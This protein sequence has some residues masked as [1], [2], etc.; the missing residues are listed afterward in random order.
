MTWRKATSEERA[1]ALDFE[2]VERKLPAGL[3]RDGEPVYL[4]VDFLDGTKG[5]H[6]PIRGLSGGA[7]TTSYA[8]FLLYSLFYSGVLGA[9]ATNT[10][11]LIF[12]V[13]GEDLLFLDH[14]NTKLDDDQRLR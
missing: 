10:K 14:P 1:A 12:N 13:K 4:D 3:S 7:T 2:T 8:T 5:A 6:V 9:E 11:A